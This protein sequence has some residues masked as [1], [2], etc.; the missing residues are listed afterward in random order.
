M[1]MRW[2]NWIPILATGGVGIT[3]ME[4]IS[5]VVEAPVTF[6][7]VAGTQM[8]L[9]TL[10]RAIVADQVSDGL[11]VGFPARIDDYIRSRMTTGTGRD[12]AIDLFGEPYHC[13]IYRGDYELWSVGPDLI[14]DTEDDIFVLIPVQ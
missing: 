14:D 13:E 10:R 7:M 2:M 8:E 3:H 11:P 12:P 1:S 5:A 4:E 6:A 9:A